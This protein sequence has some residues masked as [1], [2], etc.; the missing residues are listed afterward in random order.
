MVKTP[1]SYRGAQSG[2]GLAGESHFNFFEC[3]GVA[4]K[5]LF[6]TSHSQGLVLVGVGFVISFR[7][8]KGREQRVAHRVR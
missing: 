5:D 6:L 4:P 1:P 3:D 8:D 2:I 7:G